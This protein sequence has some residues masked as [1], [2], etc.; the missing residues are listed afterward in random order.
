M[1]IRNYEWKKALY[2]EMNKPYFMRLRNFIHDQYFRGK[3]I[4]PQ[5]KDV[6]RAFELTPLSKVKVVIVGQDPYINENQADG[7]AF[8]VK[9]GKIPPSLKN[10]FKEMEENCNLKIE[11]TGNLEG[12]A[13][14]GVL[15]LNTLLTV[16]AGQSLSHRTKGWERFTS[17]V[18]RLISET[19]VGVCFV[20]WGLYAQKREQCIQNK[21]LQFIFKAPHPSPFSARSGFFEC[22][23]FLKINE[24]LKTIG[25]TPIDWSKC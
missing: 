22:K 3:E 21:D 23:H 1:Y 13:K 20:L 10:I 15:L 16:E 2:H 9:N 18:L 24:A 5:Q 17:N 14:Q 11:K 8:S 19:N 25:E 7:L 12:L 4:Y 6:F